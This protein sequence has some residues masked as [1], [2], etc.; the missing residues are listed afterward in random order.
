MKLT[1]LTAF[2]ATGALASPLAVPSTSDRRDKTTGC[3]NMRHTPGF[4]N[5]VHHVESRGTPRNY[6]VNVPDNYNDNLT[7]QWPLIIDFHGRGAHPAD[8]Y[9]NSRYDAYDAGKEY[10]TVYPEG[11][12]LAWQGAPYANAS[13]DDL[14]FTTDLLAHLHAEY[15]I[16]PAR[17]YASGKSNGGG[18]VDRL[19]CSDHGDA[20]AAFAMAAPALYDVTADTACPKKRAILEAHGF[21]DAT[22]RYQG[23]KHHQ[24]DTLPDIPEWVSWWAHRCD[25]DAA[26]NHTAFDGYETTA[27]ACHGQADVVQHYNVTELGHCWPSSA[28]NFDIEDKPNTCQI[29]KLDFTPVVLDFFGEWDQQR[30]LKLAGLRLFSV[31]E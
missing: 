20:F 24:G 25:P 15:C 9:A 10:L 14:Q 22:I 6:G 23:S 13:I 3:S 5:V 29:S 1:S 31:H 19:A 12:D 11:V 17:V 26:V 16:D 8:Q 2:L 7:R 21:R 28:T 18:F 4:R 27:Y 30:A